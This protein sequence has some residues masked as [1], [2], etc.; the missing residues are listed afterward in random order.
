MASNYEKS[1]PGFSIEVQTAKPS[2]SAKCTECGRQPA[3]RR[4]KVK[5]GSGRWAKTSLLCVACGRDWLE[6]FRD[7]VERAYVL[8]KTGQGTIRDRKKRGE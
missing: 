6:D 4:L 2:H 7:K 8:L 3:N 5:Q 1:L